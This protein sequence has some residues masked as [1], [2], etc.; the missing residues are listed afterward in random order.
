MMPNQTTLKI[1]GPSAKRW[2]WRW[3]R[4][5]RRLPKEAQ[6][7]YGYGSATGKTRKE[8][9]EF[10]EVVEETGNALTRGFGR[11]PRYAKCCLEFM[12]GSTRLSEF[13]PLLQA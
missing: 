11:V 13:S 8:L 12:G 10:E 1:I 2:N 3:W 9:E 5:R 4:R 6:K 7:T